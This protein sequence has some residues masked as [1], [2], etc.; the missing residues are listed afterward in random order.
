MYM[1]IYTY[2][3][4]YTYINRCMQICIQ[5]GCCLSSDILQKASFRPRS[6]LRRRAPDEIEAHF[7]RELSK[8][9]IQSWFGIQGS[10]ERDIE[11][12]SIG[13]VK[14]DLGSLLIGPVALSV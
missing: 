14:I 12:E 3:Y 13:T 11:P 1:Y 5:L 8:R 6:F 9:S 10:G 2:A 7:A 4:A